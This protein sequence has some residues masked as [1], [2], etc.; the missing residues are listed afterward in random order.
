MEKEIKNRINSNRPNLGGP[1]AH[2]TGRSLLPISVG[3]VA[4]SGQIWPAHPGLGWQPLLK[5]GEGGLHGAGA[6][7]AVADP[8]NDGEVRWGKRSWSTPVGWGIGLRGW[9]RER[10]TRGPPPQRRAVRCRPVVICVV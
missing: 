4:T 2:R 5:T 10:L 1:L 8:T 6:A 7:A 3:P 9:S